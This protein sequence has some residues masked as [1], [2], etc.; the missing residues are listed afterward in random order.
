MNPMV[1]QALNELLTMS[2][3]VLLLLEIKSGRF[4]SKFQMTRLFIITSTF[5]DSHVGKWLDIP[6]SMAKIY[7]LECVSKL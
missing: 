3:V 7:L 2:F 4:W 6:R 5:T 1:S